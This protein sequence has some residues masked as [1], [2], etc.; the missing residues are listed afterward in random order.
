MASYD[1]AQYCRSGHEITQSYN[2][3]PE[4]RCNFC[5]QCGAPTVSKC[6]RCAAP[7]VGM[8]RG[9]GIVLDSPRPNHC[10]N[11]GKPHPWFGEKLAASHELIALL[12]EL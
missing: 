5:I 6:E 8:Y 10:H 12:D 4:E 1:V 7:I 2:V 9:D 11:C 3:R